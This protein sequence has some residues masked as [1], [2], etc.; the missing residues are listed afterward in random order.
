MPPVDVPCEHARARLCAALVA[1]PQMGGDAIARRWRPHG[2]SHGHDSVHVLPD[3]S[4]LPLIYGTGSPA[5]LETC[6]H[7]NSTSGRTLTA[8]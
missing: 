1:D 8:Q 7:F 4:T 5:L 3:P 6:T 2:V